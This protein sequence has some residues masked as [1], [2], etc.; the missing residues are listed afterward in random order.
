MV[1]NTYLPPKYPLNSHVLKAWA[2][3]VARV[4]EGRVRILIPPASLA[5]PQQLWEAVTGGVVDGAYVFNGNFYRQL[6]LMQIAHLPLGSTTAR[7]MSVA[8]WRTYQRYFKSA[9]EY[10]DVEL[11]ALFAFPGGQLYG[12][13]HPLNS[14]ADLQGN[15][16][17][18]LPGVAAQVMEAAGAGVMSTPAAKISEIVASGMV[19]GFAGIPEMDAGAL[20]V[21]RYARYETVVPGALTSPS[22][23]LILN[24]KKW[25]SISPQD[26]AAIMK[27]SGEA[28]AQR[29]AIFDQINAG[30]RKKAAADGLRVSEASPQFVEAL[31]QLA[32]PLETAWLGRAARA[33]VDGAAALAFYREEAGR[34][35]Q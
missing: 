13:K 27:V 6:P 18:A 21:I 35:D 32:V 9:N 24:K 1:I 15:K 22:F 20:K 3:D 4:T 5:A 28:F 26:R 14:L 10:R 11:L 8:L 2:D 16:V 29:L 23:S 34:T 25:Q 19:D 30:A 17:W 31:K 33:N 7:G 12:L